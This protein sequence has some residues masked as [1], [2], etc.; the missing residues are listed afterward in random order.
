M[1]TEKR[2]CLVVGEW[3]VHTELSMLQSRHGELVEMEWMAIELLNYMANHKGEVLSI[4]DLIDNVWTGKV[5][6]PGTVRRIISLLRKALGDDIKNPQYIQNIHK[7]GYVLIADVGYKVHSSPNLKSSEIP[8]NKKVSQVPQKTKENPNWSTKS[9]KPLYLILTATIT[10]IFIVGVMQFF[11][12]NKSKHV[13]PLVDIKGGEKDVSYIPDTNKVLYSYKSGRDEPWHISSFHLVNHS[14]TAL[15]SGD[16]DDFKPVYSANSN[17]LAFLRKSGSEFAIMV[18]DYS[19]DGPPQ[20][21]QKIYSAEKPINTIIWNQDGDSLFFSA[22][23]E[24]DIYSVFTVNI[25]TK[26]IIRLT[27]PS[28]HSGGDYLISVDES[29]S[30]LAVARLFRNETEVIVYRLEGFS[31]TYTAKVKSIIKSLTWHNEQLLYLIGKTVMSISPKQNWAEETYYV[32]PTSISQMTSQSNRLFIISGDLSNVEIRQVNN[33]FNENSG[34]GNAFSI[35]SP[36]RDFFGIYSKVSDRIYYLSHKS[37]LRQIWQWDP[38][39]GHSQLT[40]FDDYQQIDNLQTAYDQELITG[41]IGRKLFV[42]NPDTK[43]LVYYSP[44]NHYVTYPAWSTD[45][46]IIYYVNSYLNESEVWQ[47]DIS[48]GEATRLEKGISAIASTAIKNTLVAQSDLGT[49]LYDVKN[50]TRKAIDIP[51]NLKVNYTWQVINTHLYYFEINGTHTDL[52]RFNLNTGELDKRAFDVELLNAKF[53]IKQDESSILVNAFS[54]A[55]TDIME[56]R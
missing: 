8:K 24:R 16:A 23:D 47:L 41:T 37:G 19:D 1:N 52:V 7:R 17:K 6:T 43:K 38:V 51:I 21:L 12:F 3:I 15:T 56:L 20:N 28:S 2:S 30:Y 54:P 39:N 5:I 18:G 35:S 34:E 11:P 42:L 29:H 26:E 22:I 36:F 32:S 9:K 33:P 40:E 13:Y 48:S 10:A 25:D 46:N 14:S 55:Q 50:K 53:F 45:S 4:D 49:F 44:E 27:L 31:P